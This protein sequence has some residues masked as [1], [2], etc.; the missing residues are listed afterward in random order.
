LQPFDEDANRESIAKFL[1]SLVGFVAGSDAAPS[2]DAYLNTHHGL[3]LQ[4]F[5]GRAHRTSIATT[6]V[7]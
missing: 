6:A 1:T 7:D 5:I 4:E 3:T 2:M